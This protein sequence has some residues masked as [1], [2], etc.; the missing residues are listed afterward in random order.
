M[1]QH[2]KTIITIFCIS[3][4]FTSCN[5]LGYDLQQDAVYHALPANRKTNMSV[6]DFMK[7][8]PDLFSSMLIAIDS[9]KL[10]NLYVSEGNTFLL[11]TNTALSD[12]TSSNSYFKKHPVT[13]VANP[14]WSNYP[15]SQIKELLYYHV[16]KGT[17][18]FE[19]MLSYDIYWGTTYS[20]TDSITNKM[21]FSISLTSNDLQIQSNKATI[22]A[23]LTVEQLLPRTPGLICTNSGAVHVMDRY[24][25]KPSKIQLGIK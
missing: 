15:V 9:A 19:Q 1:L 21:G 24:I 12:M 3:T 6:M 11:L 5:L 8:R 23:P 20:E 10:G 2:L 17:Y 14:N 18:T 4:L 13:G 22:S 7:S 25:E 16:V